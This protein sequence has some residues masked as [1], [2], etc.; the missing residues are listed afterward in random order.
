M[1]EDDNLFARV[2]ARE[3]Y[4]DLLQEKWVSERG[5]EPEAESMA[6]ID[7]ETL[8]PSNFSHRYP[9]G[10]GLQDILV[11]QQMLARTRELGW[12]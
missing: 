9:R 10:I 11:A 5:E 3:Y 8:Q 12:I 2:Q 4:Y 6:L 7:P 1:D